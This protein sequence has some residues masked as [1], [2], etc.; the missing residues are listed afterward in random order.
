M[1]IDNNFKAAIYCRLSNDPDKEKFREDKTKIRLNKR[2][3]EL[4]NQHHKEH[5]K[6]P[7]L[8]LYDKHK[9]CL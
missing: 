7:S 4:Y 5:F 9:S 6:V 3:K 2:M 1:K 8:I